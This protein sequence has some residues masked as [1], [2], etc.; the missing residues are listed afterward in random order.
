MK[1]ATVILTALA[2]GALVYFAA[3]SGLDRIE[4]RECAEWRTTTAPY[5]WANWQV[6]QCEHHQLPLPQN[7]R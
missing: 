5:A 6:D 4:R 2:L 1:T 7:A 3:D